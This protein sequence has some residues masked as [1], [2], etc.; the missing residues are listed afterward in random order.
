M[1]RSPMARVGYKWWNRRP[2]E[3]EKESKE[4]LS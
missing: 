2:E 4:N 1:N 3:Q